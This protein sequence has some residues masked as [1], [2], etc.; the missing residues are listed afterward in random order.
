MHTVKVRNLEGAILKIDLSKAFDRA[1]WI[2]LRILLT[3]MGFN[4]SIIKWFF[5]CISTTSFSVLLNGSSLY[6]LLSER[7]LRQ[8]FP[9]SHLLFLSIAEGLS[10]AILDAKRR[11]QLEGI[12]LAT[13]LNITHLLFADDIL[14]FCG[15]IREARKAIG[16]STDFLQRHRYD[17][18]WV[19]IHYHH[20]QYGRRNC[21]E[22][23]DP[24]PVHGH[25]LRLW[26]EI[27]RFQAQTKQLQERRL[28][29]ASGKIGTKRKQLVQHMALES[30]KVSYG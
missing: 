4:Y 5:S 3:H 17:L 7:G 30:K 24:L 23:L 25:T 14:L 16:T 18:K 19:E 29:L 12:K 11:G 2:Y 22:T 8:G 1:S 26:V 21:K 6:F 10:R 9:L 20:F 28:K 27:S 15:T 13:N